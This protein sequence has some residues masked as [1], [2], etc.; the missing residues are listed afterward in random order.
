[1]GRRGKDEY[2]VGDWKVELM[3]FAEPRTNFS[4]PLDGFFNCRKLNR[5]KLGNLATEQKVS[6]RNQT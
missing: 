5:C 4:M 3:L 6:R 2:E 1:V